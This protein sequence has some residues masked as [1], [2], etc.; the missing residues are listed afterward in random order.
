[1][2]VA[3]VRAQ[4]LWGKF[5]LTT[6]KLYEKRARERTWD[7]WANKRTHTLSFTY[8][9][10]DARNI[11]AKKI[12]CIAKSIFYVSL[13]LSFYVC[14]LWRVGLF[15]IKCKKINTRGAQLAALVNS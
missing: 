4:L 11:S 14:V 2:S 1:M 5:L 7:G 8:A 13:S 3:R 6:T 15:I 10:I 12:I 9:C